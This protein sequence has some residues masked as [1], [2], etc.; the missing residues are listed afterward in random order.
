MKHLIPIL[1]QTI[2]EYENVVIKN[3]DILKTDGDA[4]IQSEND[5]NAVKVVANQKI[6]SALA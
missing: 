6:L 5:G 3:Q 2:G 4:L 1:Q